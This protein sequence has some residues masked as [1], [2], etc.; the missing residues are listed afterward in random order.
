MKKKSLIIVFYF[1]ALVAVLTSCKKEISCYD[2]ALYKQH[3]DDFCTMD[4]PGVVGCDGK[5]YCNECIAKTQG[6]RVK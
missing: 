5:N 2:E 1:L 3:K 6:I 4:C